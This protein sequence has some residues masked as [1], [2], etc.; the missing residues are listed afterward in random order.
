MKFDLL[1]ITLDND[2]II[3]I[4]RIEYN[5][6]EIKDYDLNDRGFEIERLHKRDENR[7]IIFVEKNPDSLFE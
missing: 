5:G 4:D 1:K 2:E 7:N 6:E 3:V